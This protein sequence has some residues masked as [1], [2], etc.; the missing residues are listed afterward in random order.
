MRSPR[1]GTAVPGLKGCSTLQQMQPHKIER[2]L[3]GAAL[4]FGAC[5]QPTKAAAAT[6]SV[7]RQAYIDK[8]DWFAGT[9]TIRSR[10]TRCAHRQVRA[11]ALATAN[12]H[13]LG[14]LGTHCTMLL[15]QRPRH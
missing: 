5:A 13:G 3:R 10:E 1:P 14:Y 15:Q 11:E 9:I 8:A 7:P 2:H 4:D 6:A 12:R